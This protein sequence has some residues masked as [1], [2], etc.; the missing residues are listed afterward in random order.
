MSVVVDSSVVIAALVD[1]G[2]VGEWAEQIIESGP[3]HAPDLVRVEGANALRRLEQTKR[4]TTSEAGAAYDDLMQ[5][6]I[7]LLPFDPFSERI[8]E[9]RHGATSYDA[10]YVAAAEALEV[11]LA[12]LD[13]RL[14]RSRGPRCRFLIPG[15]P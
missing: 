8:W 14:S 9:L 7:T 15:R 10:W 2:P 1:V 11:P 12:T 5:L 4:I 13:G 3:L 6:E